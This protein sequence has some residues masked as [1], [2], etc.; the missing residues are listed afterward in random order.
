MDNLNSLEL[1]NGLYIF[2]FCDDFCT[3]DPLGLSSPCPCACWSVHGWWRGGGGTGWP[4]GWTGC[5]PAW[6]GRT[7]AERSGRRAQLTHSGIP[8]QIL[9]ITLLIYMLSITSYIVKLLLCVSYVLQSSERCKLWE[10]K[11]W[12]MWIYTVSVFIRSRCS[13]SFIIVYMESLSNIFSPLPT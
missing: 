13:D 2:V 4:G 11:S 1:W 9:Y 10:F 6:G 7:A 5:C 12:R 3:W 8:K